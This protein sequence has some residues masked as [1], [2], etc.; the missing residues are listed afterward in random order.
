[1]MAITLDAQ[2]VRTGAY[3]A[4][5]AFSLADIPIGLSINRWFHMTSLE[6]APFPAVAAYHERPEA[7]GRRFS[8]HGRNGIA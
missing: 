5:A 7:S 3:V 1:M 6:H 4:G 8:E 2:L